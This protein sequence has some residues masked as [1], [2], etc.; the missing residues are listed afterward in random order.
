LV[1]IALAAL[2]F[3]LAL[4]PFGVAL[5][6]AAL[7]ALSIGLML[8]DGYF[9]LAGYGLGAVSLLTILQFTS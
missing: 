7:T 6:A 1:S 9:L 4:V 8:K 3:P 5:P 2:M